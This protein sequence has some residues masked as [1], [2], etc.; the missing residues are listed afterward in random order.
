MNMVMVYNPQVENVKYLQVTLNI[1]YY[2]H[3]I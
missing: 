3:I 1:K 2:L